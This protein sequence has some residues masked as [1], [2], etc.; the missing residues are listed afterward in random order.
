MLSYLF[1]MAGATTYNYDYQPAALTRLPTLEN[2]G[3]VL[4]EVEVSEG[5]TVWSILGE[6]V[7]LEPGI[8]ILS[9]DGPVIYEGGTITMPQLSVT[10]EY[11]DGITWEDGEPLKQEDFELGIKISCDPESGAVSLRLCESRESVDFA[12]DTEYTINYMPGVLWPEYFAWSLAY[13]FPSHQVLA[14]GRNLADVPAREWATLPEIAETPL[15]TGPYRI[16]EWQK[17]QRIIF[18]ANPY[19]YGEPPAIPNVIVSFIEDS[20]QAVSQLLTGEVDVLGNQDL[21]AG[22][23]VA[24]VLEAAEEGQLQAYTIASPTWEHLDMNLFTK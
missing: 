8:E 11:V 10:F 22:A 20:N 14:D 21:E 23:G 3:A 19:Y 5:D 18:E 4:N 12:S 13:Y 15:S 24:R 16:V 6:P 2:G 7:E 1:N 9:T 17:G